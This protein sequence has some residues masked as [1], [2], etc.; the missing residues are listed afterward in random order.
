M[1]KENSDSSAD[2]LSSGVVDSIPRTSEEP[3]SES[4][5]SPKQVSELENDAQTRSIVED[6][7]EPVATG[8]VSLSEPATEKTEDSF[9]AADQTSTAPSNSEESP[10]QEQVAVDAPEAL[11]DP[12]DSTS[13]EDSTH[14]SA[15]ASAQEASKLFAKEHP[16]DAVEASESPQET[17]K[18]DSVVPSSEESGPVET[19]KPAI[20]E[21]LAAADLV[22]E[23][24]PSDEPEAEL[25]ALE[26][27]EVDQQNVT[28]DSAPSFPAASEEHSES[29]ERQSDPL[30]EIVSANQPADVTLTKDDLD[31]QNILDPTTDSVADSVPVD[32]GKPQLTNVVDDVSR[33]PINEKDV[34]ESAPAEEQ[35]N[36]ADSSA[37]PLVADSAKDDEQ[38]SLSLLPEEQLAADG[39]DPSTI[40]KDPTV[41]SADQLTDTLVVKEDAVT[42]DLVVEGAVAEPSSEPVSEEPH[43]SA[44]NIAVEEPTKYSNAGEST[45]DPVSEEVR[46][47]DSSTA[48]ELALPEA[49]AAIDEPGS[50]SRQIEESLPTD[51]I[52]D[53]SIDTSIP[54]A[55]KLTESVLEP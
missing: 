22:N 31:S 11:V 8:V 28:L 40:S 52:T 51:S 13:V 45:E 9:N 21:E 2:I 41:E 38:D 33:E 19:D 3:K 1:S 18:A 4:V 12:V 17:G 37:E 54:E 42:P 16:I 7:S 5:K 50:D 55:D 15:L 47:I 49:N 36:I 14:V 27:T 46:A 53:N 10:A 39:S 43:E 6:I 34:S 29:V 20:L 26:V 48:R 23:K 32:E 44:Q 25:S 24:L 30:E 35:E